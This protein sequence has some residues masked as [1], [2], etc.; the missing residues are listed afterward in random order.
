MPECPWG[1]EHGGE[2]WLVKCFWW[3]THCWLH[4]NQTPGQSGP[5]RQPFR[6]NVLLRR[7]WKLLQLA[8]FITHLFPFSYL[9][10]GLI[11]KI[12]QRERESLCLCRR[13]ELLRSWHPCEWCVL[14]MHAVRPVPT[15]WDGKYGP[16]QAAGSY[17]N[18]SIIHFWFSLSTLHIPS[19][20]LPQA[21][22]LKET[23]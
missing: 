17:K 1:C 20:I 9:E 2:Q 12:Q 7:A 8:A 5:S 19:I 10:V 15:V 14:A 6:N 4:V 13:G 18:S 11:R 21:V 3:E 23:F 22:L 16:R